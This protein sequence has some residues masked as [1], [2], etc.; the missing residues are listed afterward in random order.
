METIV[1]GR[2]TAENFTRASLDGFVRRQEVAECWRRVDGQWK[3]L[4]IAYV[5]DWDPDRRRQAAEQVLLALRQGG[6][7]WGAWAEGEA[8]GFALVAARRFGSAGQYAA[9]E[10]LE[11]SRP[12]RRRGI[13]EALF[14]LA[15][16]GARELGASRLYISAHSARESMAAYR[17]YGCM[18]AEEPDAAHVEKEPWDVQL[19]YRL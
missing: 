17:K 3:L 12:W 4:P 15:C 6:L 13:G 5:E 18:E 11:V 10:E 9:L 1:Y 8:V 19:E 14:R 16:R 2:I 7:A